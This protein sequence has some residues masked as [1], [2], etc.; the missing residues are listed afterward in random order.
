L[1]ILGNN[2]G[3]ILN[4]QMSNEVKKKDYNSVSAGINFKLKLYKEMF[5]IREFE[6]GALDLYSSNLIKGAMHLYAGEE[7]VA[8]GVCNNLKTAQGDCITSNHRGH[9]HVIAMG[10]DVR[11]VMAELLG[12]ETGLCSGRGGSMHVSDVELGI[13]GANGIVGAGI[14]IACG[15]AFYSRYKNENSISVTFFGDGASNEG[16]LYESLNLA[17]IWDLPVVFICENNLYAQT[18]PALE[19][20]S[21]LDVRG[22]ASSFGIESIKIDGNDV[23]EVLKKSGEIIEKARTEKKPK[24][25]E[26][27]TYR[28][29]GHWQGD[30]EVYRT[31]DEVKSWEEN[32]CPIRSY[33][34]KLTDNYDISNESIEKIEDEA[35]TQIEQAKKFA[36]DSPEPRIENLMDNIYSQE[37][38]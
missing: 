36:I 33:R 38:K 26:A 19:T 1:K 16:V 35:R 25:I 28:F 11:S 13:Y 20:H 12:K 3:R 21:V 15:L 29:K 14:P 24:F 9:G 2:G 23:E 27:L 37:I 22:R 8:V 18:T 7:A 32:K 34:K 6:L 4:N 5:L 10:A 30:P 31:R 17:G